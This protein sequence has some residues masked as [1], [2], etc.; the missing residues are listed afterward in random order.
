MSRRLRLV[1][2]AATV[3]AIMAIGPVAMADP[4]L[5]EGEPNCLGQRNAHFLWLRN[6]RRR[7]HGPR[8]PNG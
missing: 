5:G 2:L 1:M 4:G 8:T 6:H 7:G 3:A